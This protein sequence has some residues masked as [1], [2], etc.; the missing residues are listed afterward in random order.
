MSRPATSFEEFRA[1]SHAGNTREISAGNESAGTHVPPDLGSLVGEAG[2]E[3]TTSASRTQ[4]ATKLRHSPWSLETVPDSLRRPE[5][6]T[7]GLRGGAGVGER[8][9]LVGAA[10]EQGGG[11]LAQAERVDRLDQPTVGVGAAGE[12]DVG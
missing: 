4:R 6:R 10:L 7:S 5:A 11:G 1:A 9:L 8:H 2:F 12:E 3:P